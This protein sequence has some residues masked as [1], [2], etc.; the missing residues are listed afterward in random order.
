[1]LQLPTLIPWDSLHPLIIHFPIALLLVSPLSVLI[2]AF[3]TPLKGR[4]YMVAAL[5]LLLLGTGSLFLAVQT[6]EAASEL[7]ERSAAMSPML[8]SH[9]T[10]ATET[11]GIFATLSVILLGAC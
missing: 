2:G 4:P 6:G 11:R 3:L 1:L 9:Q 10:L 7:A 8:E 5:I